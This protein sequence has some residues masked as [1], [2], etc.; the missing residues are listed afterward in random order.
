[1]R[2]RTVKQLT[3]P[4]LEPVTLAEAKAHLRVMDDV[5][6]D[7][8][9][10]E[11]MIAAARRLIEQ[12]LGRSLM[13]AQYRSTF[14][15]GATLLQLVAPVY[16]D[17]THPI[18]VSVGGT[19]TADYEL[20]DDASEVELDSAAAD[21]VSVTYWAG[22]SETAEVAPQLRAALLLYVGH[23]YAHREAASTEAPAEVPMAFETLLASESLTGGW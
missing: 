8:A 18:T 19:A 20:D 5:T 22:A 2:A 3:A 16:V 15:N 23:L 13:L 9:M 21:D 4:G 7:D 1:M 17:P 12:R 11:A 10:I 14:A 6:D